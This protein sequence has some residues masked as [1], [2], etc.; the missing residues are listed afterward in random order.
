MGVL[1]DDDIEKLKQ[2]MEKKIGKIWHDPKR[3]RNAF[4]IALIVAGLSA[5][6]AIIFGWGFFEL[7][8]LNTQIGSDW[9]ELRLFLIENADCMTLYNYY[10][11]IDGFRTTKELIKDEIAFRC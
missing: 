11:E 8:E 3:A 10:Q 4:Q 1:G 2:S 5:Y 9:K 7:Y 6:C